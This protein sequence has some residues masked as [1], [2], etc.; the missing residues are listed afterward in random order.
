M[1]RHFATVG[2][3]QIHYRRSGQGPPVVLLHAS[4]L[5][6][7]SL[8]PVA[9][10]LDDRFT[11]I[12]PDT[13]GY[14]LSDPLVSPPATLHDYLP[15]FAAFLD[16]LGL[17]R[18]ALYGT[19][20]GAQIAMEF[21]KAYPDRIAHLVLDNCAHF[22]DAWRDAVLPR[23]FP[24]LTARE[25]GGHLAT[26]WT[27]VR[28]LFTFF[29][30]CERSADTRLARPMPPAEV[31]Q[32][33]AVDFLRAG[34]DYHLAYRLAFDNERAA[35]VQALRVPTTL[36]DWQGSLLAPFT[37][38]LIDQGLPDTV[39]VRPAGPAMEDRV[40]AIRDVLDRADLPS[41]DAAPPV[42][43]ALAGRLH[44]GFLSVEGGQ[45]HARL[46]LEGTGRPLLVLHDPAGSAALT[47]PI[48][49]GFRPHRP[50]AALDLPGNGESDAVLAEEDISPDGYAEVVAQALD[51]LGWDEV[52]V[53]GRYSGGLVGLELAERRP[54]AVK[55][56]VIAGAAD[57]SDDEADR[58]CAH[59]TP[60]VAPRL[61]GTHLIAAWHMMRDQALWWPWFDKRADAIVPGMPRL[62][63]DLIHAR[64][65]ELMK[66]G[67]RYRRAY[68]TAFRYPLADRLARTAVPTLIGVPGWDAVLDDATR[69]ASLSPN[70]DTAPLP[71]DFGQWAAA[72]SGFLDR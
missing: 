53:V 55:H 57:I 65:T 26:L 18:V 21:A 30:W 66:C 68:A 35:N 25:D 20:T 6:S 59:Y 48:A 23:Y 10:A 8:A 4:P 36:L 2:T 44:S 69:L 11:V 1:D 54:D 71:D 28:D 19:A 34:P 51:A 38:A 15:T 39:A 62:A 16:A 3:R 45:L 58:L 60:S 50:V 64:V 9:A 40:A 32:A 12:A 61:D 42:P 22:E 70:A 46:C 52:D 41:E 17:Q 72:L 14:G 7:A 47:A 27:M 13:P 31:L 37:R 5:S 29:P 67:D 33:M 43:A 63:P 49:D 24:D 56:L